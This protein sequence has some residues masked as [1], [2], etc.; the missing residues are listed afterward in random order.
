MQKHAAEIMQIAESTGLFDLVTEARPSSLR[1]RQAICLA[2]AR[3]A[4][5]EP[6]TGDGNIYETDNTTECALLVRSDDYE[7]TGESAWEALESLFMQFM[8]AT[9][10]TRYRATG[11]YKAGKGGPVGGFSVHMARFDLYI[12]DDFNLDEEVANA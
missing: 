11:Q 7:N 12:K 3:M 2:D 9:K 6:L 4:D 5:L 8:H 10:D 1:D